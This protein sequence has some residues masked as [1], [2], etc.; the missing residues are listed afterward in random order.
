M[1]LGDRLTLQ[2]SPKTSD[3]AAMTMFSHRASGRSVLQTAVVLVALVAATFP[4]LPAGQAAAVDVVPGASTSWLANSAPGGKYDDPAAAWVQHDVEGAAVDRD[5][6]VW[7]ATLW[8]EGTSEV[9]SY[10]DG[11]VTGRLK[12][13]HGWGMSGGSAVAVD[14]QFVHQAMKQ[15]PHAGIDSPSAGAWYGVRRFSKSTRESVGL[16]ANGRGRGGSVRVVSTVAPVTGIAVSSTELYAAVGGEDVVR[17]YRTSDYALVREIGVPRP[18]KLAVDAGGDLWVVSG[19]EVREHSQVGAMLRSVPVEAPTSVAFDLAGRLLVTTDGARQQVVVFDVAGPAREVEAV[20][21][22]GGMWST[23]RGAAGPL[24]FDGPVGAGIDAAGRLY[25]ANGLGGD[26]TDL[27]ALSRTAGGGWRE[28]WQLLGLAFVDNA[29][30]HPTDDTVAYTAKHRFALDHSKPTGQQWTWKAHLVDRFQYPDDARAQ[31]SH[32]QVTPDAVRLGGRDFLFITGMHGDPPRFYRFD[33]EVS[34][35]STRFPAGGW[36]WH[37]AANGDVYNGDGGHGVIRHP[38]LGL[39]AAGDPRFGPRVS[40]GRPDDFTSVHRLHYDVATDVMVV[41]GWTVQRPYVEGPDAQ[42][43]IG[44]EIARIE[45]W[46]QG[47][48][49]ASWRTA[50]PWARE[51]TSIHKIFAPIGLSVAGD[52]AFTVEMST[53]RVRVYR[54]SDGVQVNEWLP[55]AE[56]RSYVGLVDVPDGIRAVRR[57]NGEYVVFVEEDWAAKVLMYRMTT[58]TSV[59]PPPTPTATTSPTAAPTSA[60][61]KRIR[62]KLCTDSG[63][64]STDVS[65]S[66]VTSAAVPDGSWLSLVSEEEST[67]SSTYVS[68]DLAGDHDSRRD[69]LALTAELLGPAGVAVAEAWFVAASR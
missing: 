4:A 44:S 63:C 3:A 25:V 8:D 29:D 58:T 23:P 19:G 7:A 59:S 60:P 32:G 49:T 66:T 18:G 51:G 38:F 1:A 40:M 47:N 27:R 62:A 11:R 48:R 22:P 69:F 6:T 35:P 41:A 14:A 12:D 2:V 56:V 50:V 5:G 36:G 17:V 68:R 53:S 57:S 37:V 30:L 65:L 13:V 9:G 39:D 43:L 15:V 24:R 33:G 64:W 34:V 28:D 61:A 54:L 21:V 52:F 10:R 42:K 67:A 20:G 16:P 55:G 31:D 45:R 46:S 26:G